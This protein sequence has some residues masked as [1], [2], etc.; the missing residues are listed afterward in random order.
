MNRFTTAVMKS[1]NSENN[2]KE[3][4]P[5]PIKAPCKDC[6]DRKVGC[7]STCEKYKAYQESNSKI[8]K[9]RVQKAQERW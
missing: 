8:R 9:A 6:K 3:G 1:M 4:I 7:H 5:M 2:P